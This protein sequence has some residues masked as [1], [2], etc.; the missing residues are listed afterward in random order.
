MKTN[1]IKDK[2]NQS[3]TRELKQAFKDFPMKGQTCTK[4]KR[5]LYM[6]Y[7]VNILM[8]F[9]KKS[10]KDLIKVSIHILRE[11]LAQ[12]KKGESPSTFGTD[13]SSISLK[14]Q[15][16]DELT[17]G[18]LTRLWAKEVFAGI[19]D[20][21]H[22]QTKTINWLYAPLHP[23]ITQKKKKKKKKE[24]VKGYHC[25]T[26]QVVALKS[27]DRK[28]C[29]SKNWNDKQINE[30]EKEIQAL[31]QLN[32]PNIARLLSYNLK[33]KYSCK[34][35]YILLY[36]KKKKS[37]II[38]N[39]NKTNKLTKKEPSHNIRPRTY[40]RQLIDALEACHQANIV[41]GDIKM[42]SLLLDQHFSLK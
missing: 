36:Q 4:N 27:I 39:L 42:Q 15:K 31:G 9:A 26:N 18:I 14:T 12:L 40:F 21:R 1:S 10:R 34:V 6:S 33:T 19:T 37:N 7:F 30:I 3:N 16:S 5:K 32:H 20:K 2:L 22:N 25:K 11:K 13:Q 38:S 29:S 8:F 23:Y 41:H 17:N 28:K 35:K 24:V